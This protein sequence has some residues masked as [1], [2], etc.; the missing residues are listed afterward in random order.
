L[1]EFHSTH[2]LNSNS[3]AVKQIEDT[4]VF[5]IMQC[6]SGL[7]FNSRYGRKVLMFGGKL[8]ILNRNLQVIFN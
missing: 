2:F 7:F 6:A 1:S 8:W 5:D 3:C 4:A